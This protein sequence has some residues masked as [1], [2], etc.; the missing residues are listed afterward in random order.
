MPTEDPQGRLYIP[1]VLQQP[2]PLRKAIL[3][4]YL[5]K[6]SVP[7]VDE[8]MVLAIDTMLPADSPNA[9]RSLPGGFLAVRRQKRFYLERSSDT[10]AGIKN[11]NGIAQSRTIFGENPAHQ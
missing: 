11:T 1:F 4:R 2:L 5:L 6:N 10:S 3:R 8:A 7:E 9:R